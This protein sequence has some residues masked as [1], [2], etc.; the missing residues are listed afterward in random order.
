MT[1]THQRPLWALLLAA[2]L[3]AP[4]AAAAP[5]SAGP[6]GGGAFGLGIIVGEPTGLSAK[7]FLSKK[8]ALAGAVAW[9]LS[10]D[11][12][13]HI[14]G[15]YLL[16]NYTAIA[17]SQGRAPIHY[18]LGARIVIRDRHDDRLGLRIPVGVGYEFEDAPFDIFL[19]LAPV[20]DVAPDTDFRLE[21]AIGGRF[22]F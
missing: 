5:A 6:G 8:A 20:L 19:E 9:S 13:F 3:I 4:L 17:V 14:Q 22:Y 16:H 18:G 1:R 15:D 11:N 12:E 2:V 7:L 10:G 21:G